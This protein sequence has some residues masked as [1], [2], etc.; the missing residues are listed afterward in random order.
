MGRKTFAERLAA[1]TAV[2]TQTGCIEWTG[3]K[4]PGGYGA[5]WHNGRAV[6]AHRRVYEEAFGPVPAALCVCHRCDNRACINIDH[7]FVATHAENMA[8]MAAKGRANVAPGVLASVRA[9]RQRGEA[10]PRAKFTE[11]QVLQIRSMRRA[12]WTITAL[13][14]RSAVSWATMQDIVLG[15]TWAHLPGALSKVTSKRK[16]TNGV[17]T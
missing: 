4:V 12:G 10:H 5:V 6:R 14:A 16:G 7:L 8:D 2:N 1:K 15:V 11:E 9:G 17:R 13:A 3:Y